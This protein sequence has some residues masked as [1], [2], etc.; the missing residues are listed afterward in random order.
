MYTYDFTSNKNKLL[1][2]VHHLR[3][4][5]GNGQINRDVGTC[6]EIRNPGCKIGDKLVQ[7]TS[8]LLVVRVYALK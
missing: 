7:V 5:S 8:K 4:V 2:L 1:F 3:P 6:N